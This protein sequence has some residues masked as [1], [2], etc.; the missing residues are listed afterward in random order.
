MIVCP[1][2]LNAQQWGGGPPRRGGGGIKGK[3][4]GTVFDEATGQ[5]V[6]FATIVLQDA[7]TGKT[8]NG[9]IADAEGAFKIIEVP[10]GS[11]N[12][13]VSFVGY[14]NKETPVTLTPKKPD[15]SLKNIQLTPSTQQLDEVVVEG[16]REIIESK[17]DRIVY[18]ADQDAANAGGVAAD[19]LRRAPLLSV[20]LEGNV[21]LRGSNNVQILI[22]GKPSSLF[23]GGQNTGNTLS[24][25]PAD[26]IKSVEVITSP[27]AKY[28][29][30][31]SAGIINIITKKERLE[32]MAGNVDASVGNL[33]NNLTLGLNAGKGRFGFNMGVN[34]FGSWP[35]DGESTF[36]RIDR[37]TG[38]NR[39][40]DERGT[41]RTTNFGFFGSAGAFYDFNAYNSINTSIRGR[42]FGSN[43]DGVF[44]TA[45]EDPAN[46]VDQLYERTTDNESFRSGFEW[47]VDYIKKF[48][49]QPEREFAL[50]FKLDGN[51]SDNDFLIN[52]YDLEGDDQ[53]LYR[54]ERNS[55]DGDNREYT[56]QVDYT[57]PIGKKVKVETGVKAVLREVDSDYFY[58]TA[59]NDLAAFMVNEARTDFFEYDQDI[60]AGFVS[61]TI[62]FNKTLGLI[63]GARYEA[64]EIRGDFRVAED[65]FENSYNNLLPSITLSKK[66]SKA[67]SLKASYTRRIQRPSLFFINPYVSEAN[68]RNITVGNPLLDPELTDQYEVSYSRFSRSFTINAAFFYR[69]TTDIIESFLNVNEEGIS[70][71]TFR[72]IG[73]N[74][75]Y[76][77]NVFASTTLFK[78]WTLRGGI[79]L[80]TYNV[81]GIVDGEELSNDAILSNGNINSSL[82]LPNDWLIDI[83]GFYRARRQTLQGFNPAFSL[84]IMGVKKQL[85]D[86][87]GAVGLRLVEPFFPNK[88]FGTEL[89]GTDFSQESLFRLPFRSIGVSFSYK[90]GKYKGSNRGRRS[91]I[92]NDDLKNGGDGGQG[93]GRGF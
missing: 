60:Y 83:F 48:A 8:V 10:M 45:F 43:R 47:S 24:V 13:V 65:E 71:T 57:H 27:S 6:E 41:D 14:G 17:I 62:N 55:N 18:N 87:K 42:G 92:K 30:E 59:D 4:T 33:Q 22:N 29:G 20:D 2:L 50:A 76:G 39:V 38:G 63:A 49:G 93:G 37:A 70:E 7:K 85:W 46:A 69:R 73:E 23:G 77:M 28:D 21:S 68:N 26:Q 78:I 79:N 82:Q 9:A 89:E 51:I 40:F 35:R 66:L 58:E 52:Q 88:E 12:V 11:Y 1:L 74:D 56:F 61:A 90:F 75:S 91:K 67:A 5:A 64:T 32:G 54:R 16:Q 44:L 3:V 81:S 53:S 86:K 19:V 72:N 15:V 31:G 25:I 84:F 34:S 36:L 80:F